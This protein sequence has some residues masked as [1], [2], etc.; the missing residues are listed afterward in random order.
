MAK[1]MIRINSDVEEYGVLV[2]D[3]LQ[4]IAE[5]H[6]GYCS[7]ILGDPD[8]MEGYHQQMLWEAVKLLTIISELPHSLE[9]QSDN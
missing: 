8:K 7:Y 4:L 2:R 1:V 5:A 9:I 6:E 3:N